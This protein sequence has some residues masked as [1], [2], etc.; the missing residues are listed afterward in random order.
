MVRYCFDCDERL[1]ER[2]EGL[3]TQY[4]LTEEEIIEQLV[5]A[6]LDETE[7]HTVR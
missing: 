2:I 1:A 7:G 4:G 6:G 3:A 5:E